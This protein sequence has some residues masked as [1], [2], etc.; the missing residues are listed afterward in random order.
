MDPRCKWLKP[1]PLQRIR[2]L[3]GA[4]PEAGESILVNVTPAP[5]GDLSQYTC[6]LDQGQLGSCQSNGPAQ[7]FYVA[8][9]VA[10]AHGLLAIEAFVLAR[11]WLYFGIRWIE[12][13]VDQDAGGNIGDAFRILAAKGVPHEAIYPYDISKFTQ[14]PG[15]AVD[16]DA[17][18]GRGS[19]SVNYHPISSIGDAL[20]ADIEAAITS[21]RAVVFGCTVTED[22]CST[23]PN[24]TI[25]TPPTG[26]QIAGGHCMTVVGYDH[27][28]QKFLVKNSWGDDW[29]DPTAGPG[30][31]WMGYDYFCD[32]AWGAS[33]CWLVDALPANLGQ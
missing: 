21:Q 7:A 26:S 11:L 10:I 18:D 1:T 2:A 16:M 6:S 14:N 28:A 3:L 17:Y 9:K 12:G 5:T 29:G 25:H 8:M 33:D 27:A 24:G 19:L 22:F 4:H 15:P 20:I 23:L 32:P 13:T 30:C 31:F